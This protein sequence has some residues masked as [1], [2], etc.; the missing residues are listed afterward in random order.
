MA[1]HT[2]FKRKPNGMAED[3]GAIIGFSSTLLICGVFGGRTLYVP[4]QTSEGHRLHKMLGAPAFSRLVEAFGGETVTVPAL[5]DFERYQRVR[6]CAVLLAQGRSLHQIAT[7]TGVTYNQVKNDRRT[8]ELLG[9]LP[10]VFSGNRA[11]KSDE[12]VI[13]QLGFDGF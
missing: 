6:K 7:L 1:E 2:E 5:A 3:L 8:A 12:Q 10:L 11:I 13:Q 4:E 9:L